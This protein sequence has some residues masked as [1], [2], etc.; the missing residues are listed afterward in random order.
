[1]STTNVERILIELAQT[2]SR[3]VN[4]AGITFALLTITE[5][6]IE[7]FEDAETN[8]DVITHASDLGLAIKGERA[9]DFK[10]MTKEKLD[11]FWSRPEFAVADGDKSIREQFGLRVLEE[12]EMMDLIVDDVSIDD[13]DVSVNDLES[14]A[15]SYTPAA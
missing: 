3:V 11:L 4:I 2:E 1:M 5:N 13:I 9:T 7:D 12:S 14:D 10:G 6:H 8:A 15:A